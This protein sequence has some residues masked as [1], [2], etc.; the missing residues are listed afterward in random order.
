MTPPGATPL[1]ERL[2]RRIA[3]HGPITLADYMAVALTDPELGYYTTGDPLGAAGDFTTAPEVS[4]MFGELLGL[5]CAECWRTMGS[6]DP[7]RLVELGPGR[8]SLLADALRA[9]K[10]VPGVDTALELH[11]V[12]VSPVLRAR[13]RDALGGR[14]ATWHEDFGQVPDG[15]LLVLANEFFDAL[16]VR[17]FERA[18]RGWCERM[19]ALGRDGRSFEFALAP[20][21]PASALMIPDAL[22]DAPLG[23]LMEVSPASTRLA[24]EIGRRVAAFG[25]AA[26]IVDYGHAEHRTGAT[27]QAVRR[28]APHPV[29]ESPG[30]ADLTA[31]VDFAALAQA[32]R[33][34]GAAVHGPVPQGRFLRA[35]GIEARAGALLQN[36]SPAQARDVRAALHRLTDPSQMGT[37]FKVLA[38]TQ[39]RFGPPAGF[40]AI[41]VA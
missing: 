12:E 33:T 1:F 24:G 40:A 14:P 25:G 4:Q 41:D 13:Q 8:G 31:H 29:L 9:A 6:P 19:V 18:A 5:W 32:A 27:L 15:P 21:H 20:P 7:L 16:P 26:L 37:L 17:Q 10:P 36:A 11:L 34:A 22:N 23:S 3:R 35:L 30:A 38:I 39:P 2:A 28:H